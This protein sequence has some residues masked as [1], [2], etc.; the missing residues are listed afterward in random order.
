MR[1]WQEILNI[2]VASTLKQVFWKTKVFLKKLKYGFQDE[3]T[4]I[5]N[6]LFPYKTAMSEANVKT[7]RLGSTKWTYHNE[8]SFCK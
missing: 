8:Q 2:F 6:V 4:K 7:N 1:K 5:K 3:Q